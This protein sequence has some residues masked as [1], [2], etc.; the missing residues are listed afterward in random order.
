MN[1]KWLFKETQKFHQ[2]WIWLVVLGINGLFVVAWYKQ[3]IQG[4]PFGDKPMTNTELLISICLSG[5]VTIFFLGLR[6][7]SGIKED[8]IYVRFFPFHLKYVVYPWSDI[9][10]C[11]IRKYNAVLEYGGWGLRY[12]WSIH[13]AARVVGQWVDGWLSRGARDALP[14]GP[15]HADLPCFFPRTPP[16]PTPN[17][18]Q[19]HPAPTTTPRAAAAAAAAAPSTA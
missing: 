9:E 15:G 10:L 5:A 11:Y 18:T 6:L 2:W 17:P 12:G 1:S 13:L 7:Q 3:I 8:G 19:H 16:P 14:G 4:E